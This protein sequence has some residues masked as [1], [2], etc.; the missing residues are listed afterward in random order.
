MFILALVLFALGAIGGS[1][2]ASMRFAGRQLPMP[3]ALLHG[4]LGA[5]GI[6]SLLLA[7]LGDGSPGTARTALILFIVAAVGGFVLFSFHLRKREL[8]TGVVVVHGLVAVAA[9]LVLLVGVIGVG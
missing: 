7:V 6:V 4:A 1:I 5:A 3:L 9:F 8:P 2:L